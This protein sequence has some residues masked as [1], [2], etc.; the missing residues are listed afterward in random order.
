MFIWRVTLFGMRK[1][2]PTFKK[3]MTKTFREYLNNF[4]KISLDDFTTY[5]DMKIYLQKFRLCF[6]KC[7]EY[8]ISL[9]PKECVFIVFFG[10]V[11]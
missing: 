6:Q 8:N 5:N 11:F 3:A 7:K 1:R 4:M 9:N 10:I 2:P